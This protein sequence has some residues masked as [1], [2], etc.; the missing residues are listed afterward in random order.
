M[1]KK[2]ELRQAFFNKHTENGAN[3]LPKIATAPHDLFEWFYKQ[4]SLG[5]VG[6]TL[7]DSELDKLLEIISKDLFRMKESYDE[8]RLKNGLDGEGDRRQSFG[9][10]WAAQSVLSMKRLLKSQC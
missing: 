5:S 7:A 10:G 3:G 2:E 4:L 6:Q 9:I 1:N 8:R